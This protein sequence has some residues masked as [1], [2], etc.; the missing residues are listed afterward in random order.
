M[1]RPGRSP[2]WSLQW[3]LLAHQLTQNKASMNISH[4]LPPAHASGL[5]RTLY[6]S[7]LEFATFDPQVLENSKSICRKMY[8][9]LSHCVCCSSSN[10]PFYIPNNV[11]FPF[12]FTFSFWT[13]IS[14]P[15][16][17]IKGIKSNFQ[18]FQVNKYILDFLGYQVDLELEGGWEV[19][20]YW[21]T[22]I[23]WNGNHWPHFTDEKIEF[24]KFKLPAQG[25]T[26]PKQIEF[27]AR[28]PQ[29]KSRLSIQYIF[30]CI[31]LLLN[32]TVNL[33]LLVMLTKW[34]RNSFELCCFIMP[35]KRK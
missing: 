18:S 3:L 31:M 32:I 2:F 30:H 16:F 14:L 6:E 26:M 20:I 10:V 34:L 17:Y 11:N 5:S 35:G 13:E 7:S 25:H 12:S 9:F 28:K 33:S 27:R 19:G 22:I 21:V 29:A 4:L 8:L 24:R 23:L 15:G 1:P